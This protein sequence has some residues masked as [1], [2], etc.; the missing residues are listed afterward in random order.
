MKIWTLY[1]SPPCH[2]RRVSGGPGWQADA[3]SE[4]GGLMS[5]PCLPWLA[6][7]GTAAPNSVEHFFIKVAI[8]WE[9]LAFANTKERACC[10][11]TSPI[12]FDSLYMVIVYPVES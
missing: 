7:S 4:P 1:L 11:T 3:D 2:Y 8:P 10:W 5:C 12:G 6:S 9:L